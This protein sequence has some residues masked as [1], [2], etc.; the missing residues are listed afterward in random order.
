[1]GR[2]KIGKSWLLLQLSLAVAEGGTI[3]G[4]NCGNGAGVL[5]IFAEDDEARVK[6]RLAQLGVAR[7][8]GNVY[9]IDRERFR[10]LASQYAADYSFLEF[11]VSTMT[12]RTCGCLACHAAWETPEAA[13][14]TRPKFAAPLSP[15]SLPMRWPQ[16][17]AA[18]NLVPTAS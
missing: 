14:G 8:P 1:V 15:Q 16:T 3:L 4:Y 2:P 13:G 7:P 11:L 9:V 12:K 17:S 5:A 10:E 6:S 18:R